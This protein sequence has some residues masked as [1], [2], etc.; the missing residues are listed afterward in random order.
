MDNTSCDLFDP[1]Q[2][3]MHM[4]SLPHCLKHN[5]EQAT[6]SGAGGGKALILA[7]RKGT[8]D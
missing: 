3:E 4:M 7:R 6:Y 8:H 1:P 2:K 5:P